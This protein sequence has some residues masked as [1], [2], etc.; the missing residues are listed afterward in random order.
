MGGN[1][2]IKNE[3]HAIAFIIAEINAF[4]QTDISVDGESNG[5]GLIDCYQ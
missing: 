1:C 4:T 3:K 5:H 2:F